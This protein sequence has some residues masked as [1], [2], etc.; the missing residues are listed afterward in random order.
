MLVEKKRFPRQKLCGEFISPECLTHFDE[1]GILDELSID[2]ADIERTV[3]YA[4]NG[5]SLA[6]PSEWFADGSH[7]L[8]LSRAQMDYRLLERAR[9]VGAEGLEDTQAVGVIFE[10]EKVVGVRLKR[11]GETTEIRARIVIDA[12]GRSRMLMREVDKISG[13][14]RGQRVVIAV[15]H[16]VQATDAAGAGPIPNFLVGAG[17]RFP[18][19][20]NA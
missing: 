8:G 20:I 18:T 4:R 3:F 12:T 10:N 11:E 19:V 2:A 15:P 14:V 5:R 6:V 7:A 16:P 17:L 13:A 1:L 9:M